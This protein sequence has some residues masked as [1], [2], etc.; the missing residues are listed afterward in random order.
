MDFSEQLLSVYLSDDKSMISY[1]PN[2]NRITG[3]VLPSILLQQI[4]YRYKNNDNKPFYKFK[5]PC[6]HR[7]YKEGDSWTE[8]T[9][10]TLYEFNS[11]IQKIGIKLNKKNREEKHDFFVEYWKTPDN[12]TYFQINTKNLLKKIQELSRS[13][14]KQFPESE[15]SSENEKDHPRKREISIPRKVDKNDFHITENTK[16]NS[17]NSS[18]SFNSETT[19]TKQIQEIKEKLQD[20]SLSENDIQ[21]VIQDNSQELDRVFLQAKQAEW[22]YDN[23]LI[24]NRALI[25]KKNL[26]SGYIDNRYK[27]HLQSITPKKSPA[28][29]IQEEINNKIQPILEKFRDLTGENITSDDDL[30]RIYKSCKYNNS[31]LLCILETYYTNEQGI[32]FDTP[33]L[34]LSLKDFLSDQILQDEIFND[35]KQANSE[36]WSS[37]N[38]IFNSKNQQKEVSAWAT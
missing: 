26:D 3:G 4:L 27:Q 7:N 35:V 19:T 12:L 16:D 34:C 23:N 14:K 30:I 15:T 38:M 5:A 32:Y 10:F 20:F 24:Q 22:L 21:N 25:F 18:S 29:I 1:R 36:M 8:E 17:K 9:G 37:I 6:K 13:N 2:L 11:A 28:E 33:G 31:D